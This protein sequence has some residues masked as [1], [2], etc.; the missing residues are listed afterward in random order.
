MGIMYT[1]IA[2]DVCCPGPCPGDPG[3]CWKADDVG[4]VEY[5]YMG[6]DVA[7]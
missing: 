5:I 2:G 3:C 4:G 7:I 1:G 6:C